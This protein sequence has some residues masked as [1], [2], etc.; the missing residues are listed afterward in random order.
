M[1]ISAG[2]LDGNKNLGY[3]YT[4]DILIIYTDKHDICDDFPLPAH[5]NARLM[6]KV[7]YN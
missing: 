7:C 1:E 6:L 5:K 4:G 2:A 3:D